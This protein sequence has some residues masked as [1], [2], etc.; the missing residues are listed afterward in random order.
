MDP[1]LKQK[2]WREAQK[3]CEKSNSI[4]NNVLASILKKSDSTR[5]A[6]EKSMQE[7]VLKEIPHL[8]KRMTIIAAIGGAAPLLGLLGTVSGMIS[9]FQ[10]ITDVGTNDPRILAGGISEALV[11]TQTGLIIAIPL[12]LLHGYLSD[13]LDKIQNEIA[14]HSLSIINVIWPQDK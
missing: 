3:E 13:R 5:I 1:L 7:R 9:L 2:K 4:I 12:L 14:A 8:E 10:I 11:T 6:A